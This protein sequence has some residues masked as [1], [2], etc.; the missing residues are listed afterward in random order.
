MS[1]IRMIKRVCEKHT[2]KSRSYPYTVY[3]NKTFD[4]TFAVFKVCCAVA[5]V[6][7]CL[8]CR[9][10]QCITEESMNICNA[11][12]NADDLDYDRCCFSTLS[13]V[14]ELR[15]HDG[16]VTSDSRWANYDNIISSLL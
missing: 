11:D 10:L 6:P 1:R 7:K 14:D 5:F 16:V 15:R 8:W 3:N 13:T 12:K 2:P 9:C 4:D